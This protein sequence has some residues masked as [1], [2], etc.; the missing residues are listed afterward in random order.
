M[1]KTMGVAT[2]EGIKGRHKTRSSHRGTCKLDHAA[3]LAAVKIV[4]V[5]DGDVRFIV[6]C[7]LCCVDTNMK[8]ATRRR[9][10]Y[11]LLARQG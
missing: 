10:W 9:S 8:V 6:L 11:A 3:I 5:A 7:L 1:F 4:K 2:V